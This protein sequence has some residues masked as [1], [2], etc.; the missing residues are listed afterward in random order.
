MNSPPAPY[1]QMFSGKRLLIVEDEYFLAE[2]TR[3][4]MR[5]LGAVLVDPDARIENAL[6][7]IED[8]KVDAVILD[9]HLDSEVAFPV[10]TT[11]DARRLPYVFAINHAPTADFSGFVLCNKAIEIEYIAKALFGERKQDI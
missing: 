3:Q 4:T 9:I 2:E 10:M 8:E 1:S 11:L 7:L 5:E 6:E